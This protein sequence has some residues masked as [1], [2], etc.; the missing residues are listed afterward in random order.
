[1][2]TYFVNKAVS[3][4]LAISCALLL[5]PSAVLA[6]AGGAECS[7]RLVEGGNSLGEFTPPRDG[8]GSGEVSTEGESI[9]F[10]DTADPVETRDFDICGATVS[11]SAGSQAQELAMTIGSKIISLRNMNGNH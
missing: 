11:E 5:L 6:A 7:S 8:Q 9:T 4:V 2:K 1:M 10:P 3:S